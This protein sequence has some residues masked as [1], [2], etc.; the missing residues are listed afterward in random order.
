M[1]E[2]SVTQN[3]HSQRSPVLLSAQI[4]VD[5]I[6]TPVTLR[7]LSSQGALVQSTVMPVEGSPII[8]QRND[9]RLE[10]RVVWVEGQLAGIAFERK[11]GRD[12]LLRQVPK[13]RQRFE[14]QF[15]RPGLSCGP[16]SAAERKALQ[17]W[18]TPIALRRD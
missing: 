7:N 14:P 8:F 9:L 10:G 11:L 17:L 4:E 13:P 6:A 18:A 16:L 2:S 12:E 15:R 5:G 3:R 1:D